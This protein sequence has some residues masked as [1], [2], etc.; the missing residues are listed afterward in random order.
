M[1]LRVRLKKNVD[2]SGFSWRMRAILQALKDYGM[3]VADN[4]GG[5]SFWLSG[6]PDP[7]FSNSETRSLRA[8]TGKDFEVVKHGPISPQ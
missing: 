6:A 8:I 7:R 1:G 4:G 2:I 3:F 5:T